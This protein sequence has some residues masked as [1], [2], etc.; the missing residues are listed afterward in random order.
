MGT[1][2]KFR[3]L[4]A[5]HPLTG[6]ALTWWKTMTRDMFE[7]LFNNNYFNVDHRLL[8]V[9]K[10]EG[11]YQG[12]MTVTYYYSRFMKLAQHARAGAGDAPALIS[13][14]RKRLRPAIFDKLF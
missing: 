11:L 3:V 12:S 9:D 10:F 1:P 6:A 2:E 5:A 14:F 4:L 8:I 13:K 7:R